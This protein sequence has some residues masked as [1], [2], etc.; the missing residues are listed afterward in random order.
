MD[1]VGGQREVG[2]I[3]LEEHAGKSTVEKQCLSANCELFTY[4][5]GDVESVVNEHFSR[6]LNWP[7][8]P[9]IMV[10]SIKEIT[11]PMSTR[12]FPSSFW[13]CSSCS[14]IK[15]SHNLAVF[16]SGNHNGFPYTAV[17]RYGSQQDFAGLEQSSQYQWHSVTVSTGTHSSNMSDLACSSG[18][19]MLPT[20]SH[21]HDLLP[22]VMQSSEL[23]S[24]PSNDTSV[25][26]ED[27]PYSVLPYY[28]H[29]WSTHFI[30]SN[31]NTMYK[32][33]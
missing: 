1:S 30:D 10:P 20:K 9:T 33:L 14:P 15:N 4:F 6:A 5:A 11:R 13:K 17:E 12:N 24:L 23:L 16:S 21:E 22:S 27:I 7:L 26:N 2:W 28:S 29:E 32:Y 3:K 31:Y 8:I 19:I 25:Q 18:S